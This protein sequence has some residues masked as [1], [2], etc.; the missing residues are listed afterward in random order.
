MVL[1]VPAN[2]AHYDDRAILSGHGPS[3]RWALVPQPRGMSIGVSKRT[4]IR[5]F[6]I[7]LIAMVPVLVARPAAA[8]PP[9]V[10]ADRAGQL[11]RIAVDLAVR[12]RAVP[13]MTVTSL[14]RTVTAHATG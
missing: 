2:T 13:S 11:E 7:T 3:L 6:I 10:S 1:G 4:P 12:L 9:G 8:A 5:G 14:T